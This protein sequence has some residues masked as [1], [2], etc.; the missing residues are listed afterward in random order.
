MGSPVKNAQIEEGLDRCTADLST[1]VDRFNVKCFFMN[2][3]AL[4][5]Y[6][7]LAD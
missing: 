4:F 1:I 6:T 7:S 5:S 2:A 3:V